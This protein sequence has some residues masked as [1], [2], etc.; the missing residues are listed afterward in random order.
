MMPSDR[1]ATPVSVVGL[2]KRFG[3]DDSPVDALKG[4]TFSVAQGDMLAVIGAS[5][6]GKSTLLHLIAGLTLPT[7]GRVEV[8]NQNLAELSDR[9][10]TLFR[11]QHIGLVFQ[12]FNLIPALTAE[13]NLRVPL[14]LAGDGAD[15]DRV[16]ELLDVLQLK[17]RRHH[18]P[19]QLSGGEQQRVAI[20]RA[21]I[22][23][24]SV[25]LA[26]EPTGNLD[27]TS[28]Q[29]LCELMHRLSA[30]QN[31][32]LI[33][34]THDPSVAIW[35]KRIMVIKDGQILRELSTSSYHSASELAADFHE[36][37]AAPEGASAC[38]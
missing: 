11:R 19:D 27:F 23:N 2:G 18:R 16:D 38:A 9:Q 14:M 33:T 32:T 34:V 20:G 21:L 7:A 25:I 35:A 29:K 8:A 15:R 1:K 22:N 28:R 13:D 4:V 3:K 12:A 26:D 37:M 30:E 6:S 24:P 31:R 36:L 5:G 10:L 17:D